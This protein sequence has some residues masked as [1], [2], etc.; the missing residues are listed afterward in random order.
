MILIV[1]SQNIKKTAKSLKAKTWMIMKLTIALL[2]F[3]TIQVSA[4]TDA[5]KITIVKDNI[6][7]QKYLKI[8]S[9]KQVFISFMIKM[10]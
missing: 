5:Q 2:L 1:G 10:S 6:A 7:Y 4:K 3:F 8:L 9:V